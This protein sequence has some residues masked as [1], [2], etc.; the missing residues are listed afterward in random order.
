MKYL[1]RLTC[2]IKTNKYPRDEHESCPF[3]NSSVKFLNAHSYSSTHCSPTANATK[4]DM[5]RVKK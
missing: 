4:E 2:K 5:F 1:E 3:P